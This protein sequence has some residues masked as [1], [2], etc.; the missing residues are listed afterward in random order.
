MNPLV[1][2]PPRRWQLVI[3]TSDPARAAQFWRHALGYVAQPPPTDYP[4]WDDYA[5]D[6]GIDLAQ[7]TDVEVAI[8][9]TGAAPR[10]MFVRDD[11]TSRGPISIEILTVDSAAKA[12]SQS[13]RTEADGL[14][15]AGAT[16]LRTVEDQN[17]PWAQLLDPDDN[18]F[19]IL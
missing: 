15:S 11:P 3:T 5:A 7:G 19:R 2:T 4:T 13:I 6:H 14:R 18:P 16:H 17:H 12:T 8:D 10:I 9:P 1:P